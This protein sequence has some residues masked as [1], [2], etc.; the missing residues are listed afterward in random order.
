MQRTFD[1]GIHNGPSMSTKL[2]YQLPQ[3]TL[4]QQEWIFRYYTRLDEPD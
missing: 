3:Q 1:D 4:I 2:N